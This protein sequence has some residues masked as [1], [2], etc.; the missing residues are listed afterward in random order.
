MKGKYV[1]VAGAGKSGVAATGLLIR[2]GARVTLYDQNTEIDKE[3]I[4]GD[5]MGSGNVDI[6]LGE[7]TD[8]LLEKADLFVISPGIPVDAPFVE[9][10]RKAGIPIWGEIELAYYFCDGHIAAITGTNGK[11]TTTTL[12]GEIFKTYTQDSFVVGNIGLP[13]TRFADSS[14]DNTY[15]AAEISSFQL[16]TIHEFRPHVSAILNLTPDHLNRHY[17]FDNYVDAKFRIAENQTDEDYIVL[18]MDDPEIMKRVDRLKTNICYFSHNAEVEQGTFVRDG[19]IYL[20]KNGIEE[21]VLDVDRIKILGEH[22]LE[23]VLAAV[24]IS[25]FMDIPSDIIRDVVYAFK[26][27]EHRIEFVREVRDVRYYNDSKGTNPDAAIKAIKA[28]KSTTLLIGGGYDKQSDYDEWVEC[29]PGKVRYLV[30]IGETA[31]KI[32]TCC[33]NHGFNEV[34]KAET[35]EDAVRFC[36]SH[37]RPGDDVLL[38][39]ACASWDMFKSYEE[40]GNL[41]KLYVDSL[42]D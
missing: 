31:D 36:Y 41:F 15:I 26:G 39:P 18:N 1:I 35:L 28:M 19:K 32:L 20:R 22:N 17:T 16:E 5:F 3:S 38:S 33:K 27:V 30:L 42:E 6:A 8:E 10:V 40:R 12:V 37:A 9:K 25:A 21:Y 2:N 29:F 14:T 34:V 11:T 13:F 7:L 24:C 23:N 4:L